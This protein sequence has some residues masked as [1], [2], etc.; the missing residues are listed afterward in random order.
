MSPWSKLNDSEYNMWLTNFLSI[1]PVLYRLARLKRLLMRNSFAMSIIIH[2][3]SAKPTRRTPT[4][5]LIFA[6]APDRIEGAPCH[7]QLIGRRQKDELLLRHAQI[8]ET[9]LSNY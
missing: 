5:L 8:V 1:L 3:V 7:V 9:I 6:D 2:H 4:C